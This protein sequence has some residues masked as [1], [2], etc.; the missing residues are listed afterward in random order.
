MN[1]LPF[2]SLSPGVSPSRPR[3]EQSSKSSHPYFSGLIQGPRTDQLDIRFGN[4]F[5][6][7]KA[8]LADIDALTD[9]YGQE[10]GGA[11]GTYIRRDIEDMVYSPGHGA[12]LLVKDQNDIAGA[13]KIRKFDSEAELTNLVVRPSHRKQGIARQLLTDAIRTAR[14]D[15]N[16]TQ[17]SL[18]T[19]H[20]AVIK[21]ST[22][23]GFVAGPS[24]MSE[25]WPNM[26]QMTR[27]L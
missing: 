20:P 9:F 27:N 10:L 24:R 16:A 25:A 8:S 23:L 7:E 14:N 13:C 19:Q 15:L 12:Y 5:Q 2:R 6:A 3:R 4:A 11:L 26:K 17:L 21:A 18:D 1:L 22:D